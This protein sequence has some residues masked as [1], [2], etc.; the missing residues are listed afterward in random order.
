MKSVLEQE[1]PGRIFGVKFT[2]RSDGSV[3][4]MQCRLG[5]RKHLVGTIDDGLK[6]EDVDV[7]SQ[8]LT[9]FDTVKKDY[10]SIPVDAVIEIKMNGVTYPIEDD[11]AVS[12]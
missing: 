2:K 12:K 6:K 4:E 11:D 9:V 8:L 7:R 1:A 10:R 5:V 3:R